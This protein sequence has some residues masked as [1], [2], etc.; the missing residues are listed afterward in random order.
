[1]I[2]YKENDNEQEIHKKIKDIKVRNPNV[3]IKEQLTFG[4]RA[5]DKMTKVVGSWSFVIG[6]LIF[7]GFWIF[8]NTYILVK[9]PIDKPPYQ[10]L[11]LL[12][13]C[14]AALQSSVIMISQRR[15][16]DNDHIRSEND[17][18]VNLKTYEL[19]SHLHNKID[20]QSQE[21]AEL[22]E[23]IKNISTNQEDK[24]QS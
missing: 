9:N 11:N 21:I 7:M 5:A 6:S 8:L 13:S 4:Q 23:L 18:Q 3:V 1:M 19:M 24:K 17:Y 20:L 10:A 16:E 14:L 15:T 2:K 12:L 22:K